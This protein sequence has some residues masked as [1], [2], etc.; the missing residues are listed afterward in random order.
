MAQFLNDHLKAVGVETRLVEL[1]KHVMD[2]Q[3]LDLPPAILG[4]I[5]NDPKKKTVLVYGHFDVQPVSFQLLSFS[6]LLDMSSVPPEGFESVI[7]TILSP[8]TSFI[9]RTKL[10]STFPARQINRM[11]G[12]PIHSLL[13]STRMAGWSV[14]VHRTIKA[15]SSAGLIS[16]NTTLRTRKNCLWTWNVASREWRRA[17][18]RGSMTSWWKNQSPEDG[19]TA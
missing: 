2:D 5:G 15:L 10:M 16:S 11:A 4:R 6:A 13:S 8:T 3:E 12:I 18:A 7:L 19:S 9:T 17:V 14:V 1:G